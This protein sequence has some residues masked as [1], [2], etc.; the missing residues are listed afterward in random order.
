MH[1]DRGVAQH[2]FRSRGGNDQVAIARFEGIAEMPKLA[3]LFFRQ[4][5]EIGQCG[6]QNRVP[7]NQALA[8]INQAFV[9][10]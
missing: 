1:R 8:A 6:M 9:V 5:F 3:G 2:C 7:V 10:E 4:Y